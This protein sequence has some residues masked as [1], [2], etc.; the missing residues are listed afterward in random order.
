MNEYVGDVWDDMKLSIWV[1]YS[2]LHVSILYLS[3]GVK[4]SLKNLERLIFWGKYLQVFRTTMSISPILLD[5]H[6]LVIYRTFSRGVL[7]ILLFA[8]SV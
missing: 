3:G 5:F 2:Y 6:L 8:V 7:I 1:A 4:S